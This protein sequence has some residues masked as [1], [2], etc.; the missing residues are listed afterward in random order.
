MLSLTLNPD[1]YRTPGEM[2]RFCRLINEAMA[3]FIS[4]ST[5]VKLEIFIP[6]SNKVLWQFGHVDGLRPDM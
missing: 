6:D 5:F 1:Y 4:Q 2:Y 3:C